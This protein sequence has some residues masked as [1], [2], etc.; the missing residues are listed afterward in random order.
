M[1]SGWQLSHNYGT[2]GREEMTEYLKTVVTDKTFTVSEADNEPSFGVPMKVYSGNTTD[3][4][5][6]SVPLMTKPHILWLDTFK[7]PYEKIYKANFVGNIAWPIRKEMA[8]ALQN[9]EDVKIIQSKKGEDV[10]VKTILQS[11]STLCPR[12]SALGSYRFFES[13]QL[14]VVPIMISDYDFRPFPEYINWDSCSYFVKTV[15]EL[16]YLLDNIK[17]DEMVE[18]GN[19]AKLIWNELTNYGWCKMVINNLN[20]YGKK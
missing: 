17:S 4:G 3:Y 8:S 2:C 20:T 1:W 10:F 13:M 12:G 16:V 15:N 18:K 6:T 7:E 14:G 19:R 11:Y 9:R 5:W